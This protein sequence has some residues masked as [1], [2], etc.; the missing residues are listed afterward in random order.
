MRIRGGPFDAR[1][2]PVA[3]LVCVAACLVAAVAAGGVSEGAA[4]S[5]VAAMVPAAVVDIRDRRLPDGW[6]AFAAAVLVAA[7]WAVWVSGRS[8]DVSSVFLGAAVMAGPILVLHLVSP[9]SM[10]FGDVKAAVV[11]GAAVGSVDWQL[12]VAALTVGAGLAAV[13]GVVGRM[14]TIPLGPF[15]VLGSA[16]ALAAGTFTGTAP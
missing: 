4:A 6:V 11:L 15:L 16:I 12:A 9:A 5:G 10:G 8:V 2:A 14:R 3:L 7:T 13:I 1:L